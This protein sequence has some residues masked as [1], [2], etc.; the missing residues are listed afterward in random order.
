MIY[1]FRKLKL[2]IP[3]SVILSLL[4][5]SII[6]KEGQKGF[7]AGGKLPNKIRTF[8]KKKNFILDHLLY[9]L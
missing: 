5:A 8:K 7:Q 6:Q 1:P 2:I 9:Y 3:S 4:F